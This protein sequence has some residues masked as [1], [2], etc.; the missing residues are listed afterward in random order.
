MALVLLENSQVPMDIYKTPS[1]FHG[2]EWIS[3]NF[4]PNLVPRPL[5]TKIGTNKIEMETVEF[6]I[7]EVSD[8]FFVGLNYF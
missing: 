3:L 8:H 7:L 1:K 6:E 5:M 4:R 2:F